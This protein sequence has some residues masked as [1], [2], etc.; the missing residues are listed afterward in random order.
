[1][2]IDPQYLTT[3]TAHKMIKSH[4]GALTVVITPEARL[5][6]LDRG[7][8]VDVDIEKDIAAV[9]ATKTIVAH[10]HSLG[11]VVTKEARLLGVDVGEIV[12]LTLRR[13]D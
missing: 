11:L 8:P 7:D 3:T 9:T 10:S 4:G 1:M 5:M 12:K 6:G 13:H 2:T